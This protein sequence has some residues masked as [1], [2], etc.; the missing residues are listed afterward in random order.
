MLPS[1]LAVF[2]TAFPYKCGDSFS[3]SFLCSAVTGTEP[4]ILGMK[5]CPLIRSPEI[6]NGLKRFG[7]WHW[8]LE[9]FASTADSVSRSNG[10]FLFDSVQ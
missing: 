9:I 1:L 3:L 10:D 6:L 5:R 4:A 8:K 7:S 2:S